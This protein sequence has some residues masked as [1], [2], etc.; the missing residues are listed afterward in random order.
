MA[1]TLYFSLRHSSSNTPS[2]SNAS[3]ILFPQRASTAAVGVIISNASNKSYDSVGFGPLPSSLSGPVFDAHGITSSGQTM[4]NALVADHRV[5]CVYLQLATQPSLKPWLDTASFLLK[6]NIAVYVLI[7]MDVQQCSNPQMADC[8]SDDITY[9]PLSNLAIQPAM[10]AV[11]SLQKATG[12]SQ[13]IGIA[14]DVEKLNPAKGTGWTELP[15]V[16]PPR[17]TDSC[18]GIPLMLFVS[19]NDV[20][21]PGM[22]EA[23]AAVDTVGLMYYRSMVASNV[24][25]DGTNSKFA[26]DMSNYVTTGGQTMAE[27]AASTNTS[28]MAGIETTW[29]SDFRAIAAGI[30]RDCESGKKKCKL[31]TLSYWTKILCAGL[32][33]DSYV[34]G[35]G[36]PKGLSLTE[37]LAKDTTRAAYALA[38]A[39]SPSPTMHFFVEEL[40]P[41]LQLEKNLSSPP[42]HWPSYSSTDKSNNKHIAEL[43]CYTYGFGASS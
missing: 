12:L 13:H 20:G 35:G 43:A 41:M 31:K 26:S 11:R 32:L 9:Q 36:I 15:S 21:K 39:K 14:M 34:L 18:T 5:G 33:E 19:H 25:S 24:A 30:V 3:S 8:P 23:V 42:S 28:L 1:V 6:N 2:C 7:G 37:F 27:V 40:R 10:E 4:L 38:P 16:L 29:E 17:A 22:K